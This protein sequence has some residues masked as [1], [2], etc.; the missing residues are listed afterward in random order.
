MHLAPPGSRCCDA[1]PGGIGRVVGAPT[2]RQ[3]PDPDVAAP[4]EEAA[5]RCRSAVLRPIVRESIAAGITYPLLA[6]MLKELFVEVAEDEFALPFKRQTDS[7]LAVVTGLSRKDISQTPGC[8]RRRPGAHRS[9]TRPSRTSSAA[10]WPV[11]L[12]DAD[13]I[14]RTLRYESSDPRDRRLP[15]WSTSSASTCRCAPCSTSCC[16]SAASHCCRR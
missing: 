11:R 9:R 15:A 1:A 16:T 8:G 7:R 5:C 13:G 10:G 14:A 3:P 12:C 4:P 2:T 6:R